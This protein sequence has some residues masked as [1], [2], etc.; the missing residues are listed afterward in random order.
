MNYQPFRPRSS[1]FLPEVVKN[2]LIINGI[3]FLAT[4]LMENRGVELSDIL[5]LHYF[6]SEKFRVF[7]LITYM[8][9]HGS[10]MHIFF[11]MFAVWMFGSAVE[12]V[13]GP[14]RFLTFYLITGLGAAVAHYGIFYF[15]MQPAMAIFNDYIASPSHE[16]LQALIN[17]E[18]FQSFSSSEMSEHLNSFIHD[19]TVTAASNSA[20]ALKLSVDYMSQF[21]A[22]ILNAPVVVGASG[23]VFGL[24]LAYGMLFPNNLLFMMFFP[25]PIKAKYF[26]IIYGA[27]ELFS[28]IAQIPGDNV[29]HF[30][31][32]GG[33]ITGLILIL[34]WR[35][36]RGNNDNYF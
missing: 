28:G 29:A 3:M 21:K 36:R 10:F 33:L 2:I 8:F 17:S 16:K 6:Q 13:W 27:V 31:H 26:V 7:Q 20:E 30:A 18:A 4:V 35:R 19:Y 11:N 24:L 34:F 32:L 23:A 1:S 25:I 22:D 12:N 15:E 5:G 14:R 9:M